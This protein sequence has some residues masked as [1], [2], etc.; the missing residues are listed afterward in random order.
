VQPALVKDS[1][2]KR[3]GGST[4][5]LLELKVVEV[6]SQ[7]ASLFRTSANDGGANWSGDEILR[8][9]DI[10]SFTA[11][12]LEEHFRLQNEAPRTFLA[13]TMLL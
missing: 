2:S 11:I 13:N 10:K 8:T 3:V 6:V 4:K 5:T 7:P 1:F 12:L 9:L